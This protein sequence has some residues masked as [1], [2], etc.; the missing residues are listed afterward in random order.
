MKYI[1]IIFFAIIYI[2][3]VSCEK[4][5]SE[6]IPKELDCQLSS[7][8][9]FLESKLTLNVNYEYDS[10]KNLNKYTETDTKGIKYTENTKNEYDTENNLIKSTTTV[11][12]G[13]FVKSIILT[14]HSKNK[15]KTKTI[16]LKYSIKEIFEYDI[17]NNEILYLK[18][19][20]DKSYE[21]KST[22]NSEKKISQ[23]QIKVNGVVNQQNTYTYDEKF[24]L[25]TSI[26]KG[27]EINQTKEY[28][29]NEKDILIKETDD[30]GLEITYT[31]ADKI[32]DITTKKNGQLVEVARFELNEKGLTSKQLVSFNNKDFIVLGEWT[33]H[34]NN[35]R[36]NEKLYKLKKGSKTESYF[37]QEINYHESKKMIDYIGYNENKTVN[38]GIKNKIICD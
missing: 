28:F 34:S 33:Y 11:N 19:D 15:L 7:A 38:Y 32:K 20:Y 10:N 27:K 6:I 36:K 17:N 3:T 35:N 16:N 14:Y 26:K 18:T 31:N 9:Y 30:S 24:R 12:E 37:L 1:K 25:K 5:A 8:E 29:Y 4:K 13:E 21:K 2:T 22:F 23:E